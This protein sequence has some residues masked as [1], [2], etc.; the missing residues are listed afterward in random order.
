[1]S[2]YVEISSIQP[3]HEE[4]GLPRFERQPLP[5]NG[6]SL[7]LGCAV[8][9]PFVANKL[10]EIVNYRRQW[11]LKTLQLVRSPA[12]PMIAPTIVESTPIPR[13]P[14]AMISRFPSAKP[15]AAL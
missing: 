14:N 12:N 15:L 3:A 5:T 7:W 13:H 10:F 4:F 6:C 1:M 11:C 2:C 9:N 8:L